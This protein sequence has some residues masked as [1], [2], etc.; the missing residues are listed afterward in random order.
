MGIG[1]IILAAI[2]VIVGIGI[3]SSAFYQDD[4]NTEPEIE[5]SKIPEPEPKFTEP[6][7]ETT[8]EPKIIEETTITE[9]SR[10]FPKEVQCTGN[11]R[12]ISDF[13]TRVIDGDNSIDEAMK[14]PRIHCSLDGKISIEADDSAIQLIKHLKKTGYKIDIRERYSFYLGAIHAVLK[15]HTGN[16][17]QGVAEIRRD[18]TADGLN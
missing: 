12:C 6:E 18:G 10:T 4:V 11:A 7:I 14:R 2:A 1:K 3:I 9:P 5:I 8:P 15:T 17:F 16:G 13:V